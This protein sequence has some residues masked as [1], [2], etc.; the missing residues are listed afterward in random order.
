MV[1]LV[2]QLLA[3]LEGRDTAGLDLDLGAGLGVAAL[4]GGGFAN[5]ERTEATE[6][7]S[8]ALGEPLRD[9]FDQCIDRDLNLL[10]GQVL[11]LR[12][13]VD[14]ISLL[15]GL[16]VLLGLFCAVMYVDLRSRFALTR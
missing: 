1:D 12:D 8:L 7:D 14:Q 10:S 6:V 5:G 4:A 15:H 3:G 16:G 9:R 13:D 11:L 2:S